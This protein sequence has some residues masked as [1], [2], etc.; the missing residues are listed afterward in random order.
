MR[1]VLVVVAGAL[2]AGVA[3]LAVR[4]PAA[5]AEPAAS[6]IVDRTVSCGV[7]LTGGI[8]EVTVSANTGTRL[9]GKPSVWKYLAD[10]GGGAND[11]GGGGVQAGNPAAPL[12]PGLPYP[13]ERLSVGLPPVCT[14]ARRIPLSKAGLVPVSVPALAPQDGLAQCYPV[15][16]VIVRVRGIFTAPTSLH[17]KRSPHEPAVLA[18]SGTV[19]TGYLAIRSATGKPLA[20]GEVFQNGKARLFVARSCD[21]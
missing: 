20:Y 17:V 8:R 12:G 11:G 18:A 13:P 9:A 4:S 10:V 1:V 19:A 3:A 16:R 21:R 7:P 14:S 5:D 2:L 6:K 15:A